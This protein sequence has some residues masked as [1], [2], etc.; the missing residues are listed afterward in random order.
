MSRQSYFTQL[1]GFA[2]NL[3]IYFT[4]LRTIRNAA[5]YLPL[6]EEKIAQNQNKHIVLLRKLILAFLYKYARTDPLKL[7]RKP[8]STVNQNI[9]AAL[10]DF[11]A[12]VQCFYLPSII[13]EQCSPIPCVIAYVMCDTICIISFMIFRCLNICRV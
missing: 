10:T 13:F 3:W 9:S 12:L 4:F 11:L 7:T 6:T 1:Y 2:R 8:S 5:W